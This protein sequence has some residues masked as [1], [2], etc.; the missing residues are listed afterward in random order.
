MCPLPRINC[1]CSWLRSPLHGSIGSLLI[2]LIQENHSSNSLSLFLS[3]VFHKIPH[4][5]HQHRKILL[6]LQ[7]YKEQSITKLNKADSNNNNNNNNNTDTSCDLTDLLGSM[8]FLSFLYLTLSVFIFS[9]FFPSHLLNP[10]QFIW[11]SLTSLLH[12]PSLH[13]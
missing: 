3:S 2:L 5:F 9:N 8:W 4:L 6:F 1:L 13:F 12:S 11:F 7:Y 10:I